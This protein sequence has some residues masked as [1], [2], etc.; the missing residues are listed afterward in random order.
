M[1]KKVQFF[2]F[3]ILLFFFVIFVSATS[4]TD[5]L[6]LNIQ[7][8]TGGAV[9]T[10]T[11]DFVFNISNNSDCA[12]ANVVYTNSTTLTTDSRGIISY[13]LPDV[14]LDY[15]IQY[16]LCYYRDGALINTFKIARTPY[17]FRAKNISAEGVINNSNL[18][19][20]GY[21]FTVNNADFNGGWT[22]GGVSIL[23]G[24]I[25]AQT[26]YFYN[27]TS[28]NVTKYNLTI[29]ENIYVQGKI[30]IGTSSPS[31]ALE[32]RGGYILADNF[33]TT[34]YNVFAGIN[35]GALNTGN[36][37]TAIGRDAAESNIGDY[38]IGIGYQTIMGN[39]A[40]NI[41]AI[42]YQ[43]GLVNSLANQF[44]VRQANVNTL[45]LIQGDFNSGYVGIGTST[46][47]N[48]LDVNGTIS[49]GDI[50]E[51]GVGV[52]L[53]S[54]FHSPNMYLY[55]SGDGKTWKVLNA[56]ASYVP[57][58]GIVRDPS[59][60]YFNNTYWVVHTNGAVMESDTN[61]FSIISS[62][63]LSNWD[64][65]NASVSTSSV[66]GDPVN[67][68]GKTWA[69]EWFVDSDG[70]VYI[71][72]TLKSDET[73]HHEIYYLTP[74]DNTLTSWSNPTKITINGAP[75]DLIDAF[76][77]KWKGTYY[78]WY[79]D[80]VTKY[81]EYATA[82]SVTGTYT[83]QVND[84]WAGWGDTLE[85]PSLVQID[86]DTW[87]IYFDSY[88]NNGLYYSE[89]SDDF[90]TWTAKTVIVESVSSSPYTI[91]HG[92]VLRMRDLNTLRNMWGLGWANRN[93]F[94]GDLNIIGGGIT[95]QA[96]EFYNVPDVGG[97]RIFLKGQTYGHFIG[98]TLADDTL[99]IDNRGSDSTKIRNYN[100]GWHTSIEIQPDSDVFIPMGDLYASFKR[101]EVKVNV[102]L[103]GDCAICPSGYQVM[104]C[105]ISN[106]DNCILNLDSKCDADLSIDYSTEKCCSGS[107]DNIGWT[108][109]AYCYKR[110]P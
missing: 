53:L 27:I 12:V 28:L 22:V 81:I 104:S 34:G 93:L 59:I 8:T 55:G 16:W 48:T 20:T 86:S 91:E 30:G 92:T 73:G 107:N 3:I 17:T 31:Q 15:D 99:Y 105:A 110:T 82:S 49:M 6:H 13:Y 100:G 51:E 44:I 97:Y 7:T 18:D 83:T 19:L 37:V 24:D 57:A 69:P 72:V 74:N 101:A 94:E 23:N 76:I 56:N 41:V 46:P 32:I 35:S 89:S 61:S 9:T 11:F 90:V 50:N 88:P 10:G 26:G 87:R 71:F 80:E 2:L 52:Y 29:N 65:V 78:M 25:Y 14:S 75:V 1:E 79:K 85:G 108:I 5:D 102:I 95:L 70:S 60:M 42:G 58:S 45:P 64:V 106:L 39:N 103:S 21:N 54:S 63:D 77:I 68:G 67:T 98:T 47:Q 38:S 66:T 84:D 96:G 33:N 4:I 36:Y 43:A 40:D 62:L 109:S